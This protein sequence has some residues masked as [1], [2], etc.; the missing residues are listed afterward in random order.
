MTPGKAS[1]SDD[2]TAK[3]PE[4]SLDRVHQDMEIIFRRVAGR[5][6]PAGGHDAVPPPSRAREA[7][8]AQ[9]RRWRLTGQTA[10][11]MVLGCALLAFLVG[12]LASIERSST[13]TPRVATRPPADARAP[14][15][16]AAPTRPEP[17][18][19]SP[20][21]ATGDPGE[22]VVRAFYG[23]LGRGDGEEASAHVVP[24]KR[25]SRAF[26]P[27]TISRFYGGLPEPL[28][29]TAVTPLARGAYRVNYRYSAGRLRCDGGAV[30]SLTSRD[31]RNLIRSI[32]ALNGC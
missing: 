26:S 22:A 31:G 23:A 14:P 12:A 27:E 4:A 8:P 28:R 1:P 3:D 18:G 11:L 21:A 24:E 32:R 10:A 5:P 13:S 7:V 15:S 20:I 19:P 16:S 6:R 25:S 29:L 9:R 17:R 2:R 30:V